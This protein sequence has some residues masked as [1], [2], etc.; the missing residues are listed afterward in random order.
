MNE[1]DNPASEVVSEDTETSI[2]T[3]ESQTEEVSET[4]EET[5]Q[6]ASEENVD[7]TQQAEEEWIIP[8]RFRK[9]EEHKLAESY[10]N[11]E[12]EYSRRGN[13]LYQLRNQVSQPKVDPAEKVQRFAE[14]VKRDPVE[15]IEKIVDSRTQAVQERVEQQSFNLEYQRLMQNKEFADLEP[16]MVQITNSLSPMLTPE[17]KRDPQLLHWLFYTARG[18]KADETV[19]N[20]EKKGLQKGERTALKKTK[21]IVEGSSGSK[22]HVKKPFQELSREEMRKELAKGRL[23]D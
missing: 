2:D 21:A 23:H 9:G 8:G 3:Q 14:A 17:Q 12:S 4:S 5:S 11:L 1:Q 10:R 13:E 18:M 7:G 15:A 6:E 20:A 22:G 16:T 19:R